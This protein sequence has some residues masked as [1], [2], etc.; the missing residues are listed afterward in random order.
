[1]SI[2]FAVAASVLL[3]FFVRELRGAAVADRAVALFCFFPGSFVLSMTYSESMFIA[4]AIG[5]LWAL[6]RRQWLLAG[7]IAAVAT[8]TRSNGLALCAACAFAA[9]VAIYERREWR[10]LIAPV[11]SPVGMLT[12]FAYLWHHTGDPRAWFK[13]QR[14]GWDEAFDP[15]VFPHT[16]REFF[17]HPTRDVVQNRGGRRRLGGM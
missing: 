4:L 1:M 12:F 17:H 2:G 13:V 14:Y 10:S 8:A 6:V 11:L 3:W 15:L 5:C 16:I 7:V 9:G